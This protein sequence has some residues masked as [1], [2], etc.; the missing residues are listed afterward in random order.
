M[1][2]H[3]TCET[4]ST[5]DFD[6]LLNFCRQESFDSSPAAA[7]MWTSDW[8]S[9][10][11]T[12]PFLL[13]NTGRFAGDKGCFHLLLDED[14]IIGCSGV[15]ISDFSNHVALLGVRTWINRS[16]RHRQLVKDHL[17]VANKRWAL[18]RKIPV[19]AISF[20]A[21]N[22][23][24]KELFFKG[25]RTGKRGKDHLFF[26]G[27]NEL[28]FPVMIQNTPQFVLYENLTDYRFNWASIKA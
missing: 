6:N 13:Q 10:A 17:L 23:N 28:E 26:N 24:L 3:I 11:A 20:N 12:L 16:Y 19:L 14:R 7:N 4:Y 15:Y 21:Y 27:C 8:Q 1:K 22:K 5:E 9:N 25:M 18:N 2:S